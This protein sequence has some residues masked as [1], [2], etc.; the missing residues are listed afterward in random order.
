MYT[1]A[2]TNKKL[3]TFI[4][5]YPSKVLGDGEDKYPAIIIEEPLV[6]NISDVS[7]ASTNLSI[8]LQILVGR[9]TN[10]LVG[11]QKAETILEE[12]IYKINSED[13]LAI[14]NYSIITLSRYTD[15]DIYGVRAT[16]DCTLLQD[17]DTCSD[18]FDPEKVFTKDNLL[19]DIDTTDPTSCNSS[20]QYRLPNIN[21][22]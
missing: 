19:E 16:L 8:N 21:I 7:N 5:D 2:G 11:Q 14:N 3:N 13:Y 9:D 1:K 18:E 4:Y 17:F 12:M 20:F 10:K 6:F 15:D 22:G